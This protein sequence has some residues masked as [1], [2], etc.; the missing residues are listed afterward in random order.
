MTTRE[1]WTRKN[2]PALSGKIMNEPS[3]K[4]VVER[5][6]T[7]VLQAKGVV[8]VAGGISKTDPKKL[9]IQVYVTINHW[10]DGLPHQLDG[11]EVELVKTSG[12]RA[13]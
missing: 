8:G 9:S 6:R 7:M 4:D 11:F 10:P 5:H 12:F 2:A 13:A 1:P 3:L